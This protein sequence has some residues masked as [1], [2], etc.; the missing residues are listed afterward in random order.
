MRINDN[1]SPMEYLQVE[2]K[3]FLN[4]LIEEIQ[5]NPP[6]PTEKIP[7]EQTPEELEEF[8]N[9]SYVPLDEDG[10]FPLDCSDTS[11]KISSY[12]QRLIQFCLRPR[13]ETRVCVLY[14]H[15]G[16][17]KTSLLRRFVYYVYPKCALLKK[18]FIPVFLRLTPNLVNEDADTLFKLFKNE[19]VQSIYP[20]IQES[21]LWDLQRVLSIMN[22]QGRYITMF[23]PE[24]IEEAQNIGGEKW[25]NSIFQNSDQKFQFLMDLLKLLIQEKTIS[26]VLIVDD[27]DRHS[28]G[29]HTNVFLAIDILGEYGIGCVV[30]MR[31]STYLTTSVQILDLRD[32]RIELLVT[33]RLIEQ[34][35]KRRL[36]LLEKSIPLHPDTPFRV[37]AYTH[38][39]G[40]DVVECFC[41]LLSRSPC[42][43]ALINLSNTNLKSVFLKLELMTSSDAFSDEFIVHQLLERDLLS[44]KESKSSRIWIFYHLLFGNYA[45]TFKT[46]KTTAKAGL[47]NLFD[48][49]I[50][51]T[52][53][54][55]HFIRVNVLIYFY[56]HWWRTRDENLYIPMSDLQED[57][58]LAFGSYVSMSL[59]LD[60]LNALVGSELVFMESCRRYAED[61][62]LFKQ[63]IFSDSAQISYAGRFYIDNLVHKVE[64]LYFIKDDID[65]SIADLP[66]HLKAA[67]RDYNRPAKFESVI[68]ALALLQREEYGC[69][70]KYKTFRG[71]SDDGE[72]AIKRYR[73][74]F[75]PHSL[76]RKSQ[77]SI[78]DT[79]LDN[80]IRFIKDKMGSTYEIS[81][82][83]EMI[84]GMTRLRDENEGIKEAFLQV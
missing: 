6:F 27:V 1:V 31:T 77:I 35:L 43:R 56:K 18:K 45:G 47:V 84:E 30:S 2:S 79:V 59:L 10:V 61:K 5:Y 16:V 51:S 3:R 82:V 33:P 81:N 40:K 26:V 69:L 49:S 64:Y 52:D 39:K 4:E 22:S 20:H 14:G 36:K 15:T 32:Q 12:E 62:N 11:I 74:M 80:Y 9:E 23:S 73:D 46:S 72:D 37:S 83:K 25:L 70:A 66:P 8:F 71:S 50:P 19:I 68:Q 28:P 29:V 42:M 24:V 75:S 60:T 17:G 48:S 65:F 7:P 13:S 34:I 58:K 78:C 21:I 41:N 55:R 76:T 67:H 54:W 44:D 53:P 63:H 38:V 57:F